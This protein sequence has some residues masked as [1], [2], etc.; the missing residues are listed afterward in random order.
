MPR[1]GAFRPG[2]VKVRDVDLDG[3][4]GSGYVCDDIDL[5]GLNKCP[6]LEQYFPCEKGCEGNVGSD[7]PAY[8][9]G[10]GSGNRGKCFTNA[11]S[12]YFSCSGRHKATQRLCPCRKEY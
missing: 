4:N 1:R 5:R 12:Q 8:V 10:G 6:V 3:H 2:G 9:A 7:Q 11:N